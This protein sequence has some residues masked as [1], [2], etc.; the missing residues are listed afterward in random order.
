MFAILSC[1]VR[2]GS[3]GLIYRLF[4]YLFKLVCVKCSLKELLAGHTRVSNGQVRA[5]SLIINGS[6]NDKIL[7]ICFSIS[8]NTILRNCP[9]LWHANNTNVLGMYL[10]QDVGNLASGQ[11]CLCNPVTSRDVYFWDYNVTAVITDAAHRIQ[12][13]DLFNCEFL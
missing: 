7:T 10:P 5:W 11:V 8:K 12:A 1:C 9:S 2:V 3:Y 13:I 4:L 6:L